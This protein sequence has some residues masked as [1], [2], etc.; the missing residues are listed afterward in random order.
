[1]IGLDYHSNQLFNTSD[2]YKLSL[3]FSEDN[4]LYTIASLSTGK[5]IAVKEYDKLDN[6]YLNSTVQLDE[7]FGKENLFD[8]RIIEVN[9]AIVIKDY[10]LVPAKLFDKK[11]KQSILEAVSIKAY[12]DDYT[13]LHSFLD[14]IE[15][16]NIFAFPAVLYKFLNSHY[17]NNNYY[18]ANDPLITVAPQLLAKDSFLLAN[19]NDGFLQTVLYKEKK[20]I[21]SNVY[22][23]KSKEDI[24]YRI[25]NLLNNNAMPVNIANVFLSGR[26][27]KDSAIFE[28]LYRHIKNITFVK[29]IPRYHFANVFLGKPV[30]LFFDLYAL[31]SSSNK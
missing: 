18:H 14:N 3:I 30:H 13:V 31:N 11:T 17:D 10:S 23:I 25:L 2:T 8:E 9:S 22:S 16:V 21:Q 28:L 5:I 29:D 7:L 1:M 6:G 20:F 24:L 26:L 15:A 27:E 12:L 4:F 19:F